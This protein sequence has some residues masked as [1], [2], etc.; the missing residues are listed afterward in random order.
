M[1]IILSFLSGNYHKPTKIA[2]LK[3]RPAKRTS[4]D[5]AADG[6]DPVDHLVRIVKLV[7]TPD[8]MQGSSSVVGSLRL[9]YLCLLQRRGEGSLSWSLRESEAQWKWLVRLMYDRRSEVKVLAVEVLSVVLRQIAAAEDA[10]GI[11]ADS[12][13]QTAP[14]VHSGPVADVP[15]A[16][17]DD[18]LH[19][20]PFELLGHLVTDSTE[21]TAL[22]TRAIDILVHAYT[23]QPALKTL[24]KVHFKLSSV[25]GA[26]FEC[27]AVKD[28][29]YASCCS[30]RSALAALTQLVS[31]RDDVLSQEVLQ[32]ART[33]KL[34]PQVVEVLNVRVQGSLNVRA[35]A[36]VSVFDDEYISRERT[37]YFHGD[38]LTLRAAAASSFELQGAGWLALQDAA[39]RAEVDGMRASRAAACWLFFHLKAADAALFDECVEHS[40][41]VYHL[42]TCFSA[43][44]EPIAPGSVFG[45][46]F[47]CASMSAQAELLSLLISQEAAAMPSDASKLLEPAPIGALYA[48]VQ[49]NEIVPSNVLKKI[50]LVLLN[51]MDVRVSATSAP[52]SRSQQQLHCISSC[53]RLLS[54][55]L[56]EAHWRDLL[57]LGGSQAH[58]VMSNTCAYMFDLLLSLRKLLSTLSVGAG[59]QGVTLAAALVGRVDV[60]MA[61]FMQHS[62]EARV[63]FVQHSV[64]QQLAAV[65]VQHSDKSI[66]HQHIDTITSAVE[67]LNRAPVLPPQPSS[68]VSSGVS[69]VSTATPTFSASASLTPE[70]K[71]SL[72]GLKAKTSS[73]AG[74]K[75]PGSAPATG[76]GKPA[77]NQSMSSWATRTS[78][79]SKW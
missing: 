37:T 71:R 63:L 2:Q 62:Y 61:L 56:N 30:I 32:N 29:D 76:A 60:T 41:L 25:M 8:S 5:S 20:P 39:R 69:V 55:I 33:M 27:L 9:L 53:L 73:P 35:L 72:Q 36:R 19:W 70:A 7:R 15:A 17:E 49:A 3:G 46:E 51:I 45:F 1:C 6:F 77:V 18:L 13:A 31:T 28:C 34:L 78:Q 23:E 54:L 12:L 68:H 64:H 65:E 67:F 57:G 14:A 75:T 4:A 79:S 16:V 22:R 74:V 38:A 10:L 50:V 40:N 66:F 47:E 26:L 44:A 24:A 48:Y 21:S 42:T 59:E 43:V 58:T 52:V 11:T